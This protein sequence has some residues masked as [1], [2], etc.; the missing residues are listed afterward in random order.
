QFNQMDA[1][2]NLPDEFRCEIFEQM[3]VQKLFVHQAKID[4]VFVDEDEIENELDRRIRYFISM[5]GSV[6]RLEEYYEKSIVEIKDEFRKDISD[7]LLAQRMQGTIFANVK[8]TPSEVKEYFKQIPEDSL[9]YYNAEVELSQ[10]VKK[11]EISIEQR[12]LA[13]EKIEGILARVQK[14]EDFAKLAMIYSEDPGS[15]TKG[16]DLGYVGRG[17]LVTEFEGAAF[18]LQPDEVSEVVKTKY[19]YH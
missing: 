5:I 15:A 8:V 1:E 7:Q 11:P 19:G 13:I 6:E 17:E 4:S 14:G 16:G 10:I 18:R 12:Q 9:P 3:L 2:G